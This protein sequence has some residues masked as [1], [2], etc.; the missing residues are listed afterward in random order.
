MKKIIYILFASCLFLTSCKTNDDIYY[1]DM[2][3]AIEVVDSL[4]NNLLGESSNL[5]HEGETKVQIG[6][7]EFYIDCQ[8][9]S[10]FTFRRI[11]DE[12][13]S[14]L[15]IGSWCYDRND[16]YVI[17]DWGGDIKKDVIVFSYDSHL[18]GLQSL[19]HDF[20][21][22]YKITINGKNMEL[23]KETG[24]YIYVKDINS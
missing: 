6:K 13:N 4:G 7:G 2:Y 17:I 19:S 22:P 14:Y 10:E 23:N 3:L 9:N 8:E 1:S 11:L 16:M 18:D 24:H 21:Y 15:K 5:I 20:K 12:E